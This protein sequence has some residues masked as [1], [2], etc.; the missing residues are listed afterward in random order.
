MRS[1]IG[2]F[3][4]GLLDKQTTESLDRNDLAA[5]SCFTGIADDDA[6]VKAS[7]EF[8]SDS[9]GEGGFG[10]VCVVTHKPSR[11][12]FA[13]KVV[14]KAKLADMKA[15]NAFK[16]ETEIHLHLSGN[17]N[18]VKILDSFEDDKNIYLIMELCEGGTLLDR[19]LKNGR[20]TEKDAA[21]F[22]RTILDF[23][24]YAQRMGIV[25]RDIKLENFLL[26]SKG[27]DAV[28]KATDFGL[29]CFLP[30]KE[31]RSD[32]V[33][34]LHYTAPEVFLGSYAYPADIWSC[35]IVVYAM[36]SELLPFV[37]DDPHV[38]V[39][40]I[41]KAP[42]E[43]EE[44]PWLAVSDPAKNFVK[45]ML[46]RNPFKRATC[47]A[48]LRHPWLEGEG[49]ALQG[50]IE[51]PLMNRILKFGE[52]PRI[53]KLLYI[54]LI[55][56]LPAEYKKG[57]TTLIGKIDMNKDGKI[58]VAELEKYYA[59]RS[60]NIK[61]DIASLMKAVDVN[62]CGYLEPNQLLAAVINVSV[63]QNSTMAKAAFGKIDRANEGV[64]GSKEIAAYLKV[65]A[66]SPFVAEALEAID[67]NHEGNINLAKFTAFWLDR[68][69]DN[70]G[71]SPTLT[72]RTASSETKSEEF[73]YGDR[74]KSAL[75]AGLKVPTKVLN[76]LEPTTLLSKLNFKS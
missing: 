76:Y 30:V 8:G 60:L 1:E 39:K 56:M 33:G 68:V 5:P 36:L 48:L 72:E 61:E 37:H 71:S 67:K 29:S 46:E 41:L 50:A 9:L 21:R 16:I 24:N 51:R 45:S 73:Q 34:T 47:E 15:L 42:I 14:S 54:D 12:K 6:K 4:R 65:A 66:D 7:Y 63:F 70:L 55:E 38:L 28:L 57:M 62:D 19:L 22:A 27:S 31:T 69:S 75:V 2:S 64:I 26:T 52:Q 59:F 25:H 35:G 20:F 43:M 10:K 11:T 3:L 53:K 13:C 44:G 32:I 49:V 74:L 58:Q 23:V 17:P 40:Y 18:V